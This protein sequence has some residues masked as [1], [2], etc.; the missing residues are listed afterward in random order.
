MLDVVTKTTI[1]TGST[2]EKFV[3]AALLNNIMV[4]LA[5]RIEVQLE[6]CSHDLCQRVS[7]SDNSLLFKLLILLIQ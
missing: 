2:E 4:T 5:T 1:E 6:H 3:P 7:V